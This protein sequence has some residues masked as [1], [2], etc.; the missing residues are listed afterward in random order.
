MSD[1]RH[2]T[3]P[4]TPG[5]TYEVLLDSWDQQMDQQQLAKIKNCSPQVSTPL[6]VGPGGL[7]KTASIN[8]ALIK[9][10]EDKGYTPIVMKEYSSYNKMMEQINEIEQEGGKP[11]LLAEINMSNHEP[12]DFLGVAD[13]EDIDLPSGQQEVTTFKPPA[14]IKLLS[15][16]PSAVFLDEVTNTPDG[17]L[18]NI[19]MKMTHE[20]TVGEIKFHPENIVVCAGNA[21]EDSSQAESLSSVLMNRMAKYTMV[22]PKEQEYYSYLYDKYGS[23]NGVTGFMTKLVSQQGVLGGDDTMEPTLTNRSGEFA[24]G[25]LRVLQEKLDTNEISREDFERRLTRGACANIGP[26]GVD[27]AAFV[28]ESRML[29]REVVQRDEES[30]K[31][32]I[33]EQNLSAPKMYALISQIASHVPE[34][35]DEIDD[36]SQ[37]EKE[38]TDVL[39]KLKPVMEAINESKPAEFM[40]CLITTSDTFASNARMRQEGVEGYI[41]TSYN[42]TYVINK[43]LEGQSYEELKQSMPDWRE[44]DNKFDMVYAFLGNTDGEKGRIDPEINGKKN[45]LYYPDN[46]NEVQRKYLASVNSQ[47]MDKQEFLT[48]ATKHANH[49]ELEDKGLLESLN[50]E[51][52]KKQSKGL[53]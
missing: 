44:L 42:K 14:K 47:L 32:Y 45:P 30:V 48:V 20:R 52:S 43:L 16:Y 5:D 46:A 27:F 51:E 7:G 29:M 24:L 49:K 33:K 37:M 2:T 50:N 15:E 8:D 22:P 21:E 39:N 6:I 12:V 31:D 26:Q 38:R 13:Q 41:G 11:F 19:L 28:K 17:P 18:R 23:L 36:T 35:P 3:A 1:V 25:N 9:L 10:A 4:I 53:R 34:S 40:D